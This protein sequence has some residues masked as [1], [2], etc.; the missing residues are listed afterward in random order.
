MKKMIEIALNHDVQVTK[1]SFERA[2]ASGIPIDALKLMI[3]R[4]NFDFDVNDEIQNFLIPSRVSEPYYEPAYKDY[5]LYL[6]DNGVILKESTWKTI[7]FNKSLH[8]LIDLLK[9]KGYSVPPSLLKWVIGKNL[10]DLA[11]PDD[12]GR[13]KS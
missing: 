6:V 1:L 13:S 4:G 2:M 9:E 11:N 3:R 7:I 8:D 12:G 10:S 5:I